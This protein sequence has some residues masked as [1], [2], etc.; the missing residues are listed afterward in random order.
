MGCVSSKPAVEDGSK[1]ERIHTK[2]DGKDGA[3]VNSKPL[4]KQEYSGNIQPV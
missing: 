2:V 4:V 3:K 1:V